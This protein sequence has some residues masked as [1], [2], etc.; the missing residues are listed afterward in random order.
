MNL[1]ERTS[2]V[3]LH[4]LGDMRERAEDVHGGIEN[5]HHFGLE[6]RIFL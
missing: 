4:N 1:H 2:H 5:P 6:S 3:V